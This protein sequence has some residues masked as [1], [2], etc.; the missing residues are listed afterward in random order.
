MNDMQVAI[1][2]AED[3]NNLLEQFNIFIEIVRILRQKCPWDSQQT[4]E[5]ISH[6]LIEEAYETL[7]AIEEKNDIHFSEELG[8]LLLH[9]VM[10]CVMAEERGAFKLIDVI[11]KIQKKLIYRHPH[12]FGNIEVSGSDEVVQNWEALKM[13]EGRV[14]ILDGV[15][16]TLPSLLRAQRIQHKASNVGFD[17]DDKKEVWKKV[18]EELQE[19]KH[20]ILN[21]NHKEATQELGDLIFSIVN[22]ARFEDIVAEEALQKTNNKFA[23]R[24]QYIE[25]KVK[26]MGRTLNEMTLAEMDKIWEEAKTVKNLNVD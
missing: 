6:L 25:K 26:E 24:F 3:P 16:K 7:S 23:Q 5:S 20:E 15:P 10:H 9:I 14:S 21:G 12:V 1:P 17:W 4:N 22:A 13:K 18:E 19:L 11:N 2:K 8:D